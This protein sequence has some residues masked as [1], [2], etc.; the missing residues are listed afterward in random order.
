[1][2][3]EADLYQEDKHRKLMLKP[4]KETYNDLHNLKGLQSISELSSESDENDDGEYA[5]VRNDDEYDYPQIPQ[6]SQIRGKHKS[7]MFKKSSEV[8]DD[9]LYSYADTTSDL[10][11]KRNTKLQVGIQRP[12]IIKNDTKSFYHLKSRS[13]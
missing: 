9:D 3:S 10:G 4:H 2:D 13:F 8:D 7:E 6:E 12:I 1:M 5:E 11:I